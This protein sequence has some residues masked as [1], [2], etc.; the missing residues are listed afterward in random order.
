MPWALLL[1]PYVA[2]SIDLK[3]KDRLYYHVLDDTKGLGLNFE[4]CHQGNN[5]ILNSEGENNLTPFS[6]RNL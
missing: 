4:Q 6:H 2:S 3:L 5:V 1:V